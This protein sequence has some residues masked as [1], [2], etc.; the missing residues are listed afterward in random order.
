M[1]YESLDILL[2]I[3]KGH[4]LGLVNLFHQGEKEFG[5]Y[6]AVTDLLLEP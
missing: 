5:P 4:I 1:V 3:M 6:K 2:G